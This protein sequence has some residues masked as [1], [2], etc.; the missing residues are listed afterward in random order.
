MPSTRVNAAMRWISSG[1]CSRKMTRQQAPHPLHAPVS[2]APASVP[3]AIADDRSGRVGGETTRLA[4]SHAGG[5]VAPP[6]SFRYRARMAIA[7]A[8]EKRHVMLVEDD[9]DSR[10]SLATLF[11]IEGYVV[12]CAADGEEALGLLARGPRPCVIIL[13]LLMPGM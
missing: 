11:E 10:E 2:G 3:S 7:R 12:I 13:D 6:R 8:E 4:E 5:P 1:D 9:P